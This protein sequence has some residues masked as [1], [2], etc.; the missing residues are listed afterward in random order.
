MAETLNSRRN[1]VSTVRSKRQTRRAQSHAVPEVPLNTG[2]SGTTLGL[3][4]T[5]VLFVLIFPTT[6]GGGGLLLLVAPG[7]RHQGD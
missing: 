6:S 5:F 3:G 1:L 7:S 2:S 4:P